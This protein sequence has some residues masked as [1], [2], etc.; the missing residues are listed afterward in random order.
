MSVYV[1]PIS[2]YPSRSIQKSARRWGNQWCH[3]VADTVEELHEMA[4]RI[5]VPRKHFQED[6][7]HWHYDLMPTRRAD[8]VH[9]GALEVTARDIGEM[10]RERR[11]QQQLL[12]SLEGEPSM[13]HPEGT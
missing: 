1:D 12:R 5:G 2:D 11:R 8:A 10:M 13:P 4:R 7:I 9:K 6:P 3:M